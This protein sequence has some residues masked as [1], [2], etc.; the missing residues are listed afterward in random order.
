MARGD[1]EQLKQ[2][3][4]Q[5]LIEYSQH[6]AESDGRQKR[7]EENFTEMIAELKGLREDM[8]PIIKVYV[9]SN[10]AWK[11]VIGILGGFGT[12]IG[13]VWGLIQILTNWHK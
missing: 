3:F 13:L 10:F 9:G 5:H 1:L 8:K 2:S 11:A 7:L 4:N 12:V 6:V